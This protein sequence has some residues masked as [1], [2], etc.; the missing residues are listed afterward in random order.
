MKNILL[1]IMKIIWW[2]SGAD[3]SI[4]SGLPTEH[5]KYV[6]IGL[7]VIL[8][9]IFSGTSAGYTMSW[10]F[11]ESTIIPVLFGIFWGISIFNIDRL[12]ISTSIKTTAIVGWDEL[13]RL[14]FRLILVIMIAFT[15][16]VPLELK[17]FEDAILNHIAQ[18]IANNVKSEYDDTIQIYTRYREE[19][20]DKYNKESKGQGGTGQIGVGNVAKQYWDEMQKWEKKRDDL[21]DKRKS[22]V[23]NTL[24]NFEINPRQIGFLRRYIALEE[25]SSVNSHVNSIK[26]SITLLFIIF[27]SL[28]VLIK[29]LIKRGPY[30]AWFEE[31]VGKEMP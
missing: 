18:Q 31:H 4:L 23:H 29:L 7:T 30:D 10:V 14:L 2:C 27:E 8:T 19:A 28:P 26:F 1:M 3:M 20:Y 11:P 21:I 17:L 12:I 6:G 13:W 25:L 22:A 16:S 5:N 9:G 15:I 24:K